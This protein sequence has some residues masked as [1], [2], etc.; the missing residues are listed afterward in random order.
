MPPRIRGRLHEA[1]RRL[2]AA[3][4]ADD[5]DEGHLE[6]ELL[7]GEAAGMDRTQVIAAGAE[8]PEPD[9]LVRFGTLLERRLGHEPLAYILGRREFYGLS[10]AVGPGVLVPRPETET[11]VEATLA[12]VREHPGARRVVR[13]ADVGTGCGAVALAVAKHAPNAKLF[14]TDASTEALGDVR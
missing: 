9:A 7:Y 1:A 14:A 12:A 11:L 5:L 3:Q 10:F 8:V 2:M 4:A 13:V 6:A